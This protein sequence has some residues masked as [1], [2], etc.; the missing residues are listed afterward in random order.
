MQIIGHKNQWRLLTKSAQTE[1]LSHT[2]LFIG[3]EKLGKKTF[4]LEFIKFINGFSDLIF[5]K[6]ENDRVIQISQIRELNRKLSLRSY[7]NSFKTAIIDNAHL[8]TQ[9]AQ[10]ALLKTLEE[11]GGKTLLILITEFPESLFSTILSRTQKIKFFPVKKEEIKEYLTKQGIKEGEAEE[12][13]QFSDGRPGVVI[14]FVL[15]SEK[16]KNKNKII[17]ELIILIKADLSFRFQYVKDLSLRDN[18]K[19]ILDIW[20]RYFR[21]IL[22]SEINSETSSKKINKLKIIVE[23]IQTINFLISTTNVNIRLA[24]EILMLKF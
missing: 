7:S 11:P 4:A 13:N 19:E 14:D 17:Q 16:L 15:N 3:Q 2:Y 5:V 8:M 9:E 10:N 18:I 22:I 24:L 20:L 6:P 12:I 23:Q 21:K 1:R